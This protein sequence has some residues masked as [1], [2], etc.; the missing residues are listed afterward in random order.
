ML[1]QDADR[2]PASVHIVD[3]YFGNNRVRARLELLFAGVRALRRPCV[4]VSVYVCVCVCPCTPERVC[5]V[6][7]S[8]LGQVHSGAITNVRTWA[9]R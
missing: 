2:S 7:A 5:S 3:S 4:S 9:C 8:V 6:Q 1:L